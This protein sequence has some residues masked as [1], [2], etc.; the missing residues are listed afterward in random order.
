M[1]SISPAGNE[2]IELTREQFATIVEKVNAA[3]EAEVELLGHY[4]SATVEL[5]IDPVPPETLARRHHISPDGSYYSEHCH[6]PGDG[7]DWDWEPGEE[8]S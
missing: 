7:L 1:I 5:Y 6:V 4:P 2:P 3:P 8:E